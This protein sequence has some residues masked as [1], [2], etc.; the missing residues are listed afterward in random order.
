MTV[1][2]KIRKIAR[3]IFLII[4]IVAAFNTSTDLFLAYNNS[5]SVNE[6]LLPALEKGIAEIR[7]TNSEKLISPEA[8]VQLTVTFDQSLSLLKD[9]PCCEGD[10]SR[11]NKNFWVFVAALLALKMIKHKSSN[12]SAHTTA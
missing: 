12:Q 9:V 6:I 1:K 4:M 11:A 3:V 8:K 7:K 5:R 2:E 10:C